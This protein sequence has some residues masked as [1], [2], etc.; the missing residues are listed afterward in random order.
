MEENNE[1]GLA[2]VNQ[3][4]VDMPFTD[5]QACDIGGATTRFT[6]MWGNFKLKRLHYVPYGN[7]TPAVWHLDETIIWNLTF[8]NIGNDI[9]KFLEEKW[10]RETAGIVFVIVTKRKS[11]F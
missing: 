8:E 6:M 1:T 9:A 3:Q 2:L 10:E 4:K 11:R 7:P 5:I